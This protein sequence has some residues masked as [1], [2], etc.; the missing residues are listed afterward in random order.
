MNTRNAVGLAVSCLVAA[1]AFA[2]FDDVMPGVE[3]DSLATWLLLAFGA[4]WF[5]AG[6][7]T[8]RRRASGRAK[9]GAGGFLALLVVFGGATGPAPASAA[10][11]DLR[12]VEAAERQD[13]ESARALLEA[14]ADINAAQPDG[15]TA[16]HWAV[17]WNDLPTAA[18][19]IEAGAAIDAVN[20]L[21][22]PP[23]WIALDNGGAA[24]ALQLIEAGADVRARLPSGETMLMTAARNGLRTLVSRL[25]AGGADVRLAEHEA[26]QTALM[27]AAAGGHTDLVRLLAESGA[28]V[29]A[30]STG[31]FTALMFAVRAGDVESA[32]ILLDAGAD[33]EARAI[34]RS[35][36][37][38]IASR[39]T[40]ALAG[41][42]WRVIPFASG[43]EETAR[44]L[45]ERGADVTAFDRLGR[46]AIHAAV[47][48]N[49]PELVRAL[50]AAGADVNA[51]YADRVPA[52]RGDY[53]SRAPFK[54]ATPFWVA[55]RDANLEMMRL[56]LDA[57]AD[58]L[59]PNTANTTPLMIASGLGENDARRPPDHRVVEA[60]QMLLDLGADV[61]AVNRSGQTALHGAASMWEDGVIQLL[62]DNGADVNAEDGSGRT[63]LHLVEYGNANAPSESTAELLRA[64]GAAEPVVEQ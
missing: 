11:D 54:G 53:V 36:P 57:G 63:P 19:L 48:T 44:L 58:P 51:R 17:H 23:L 20:D 39:S 31:R 9:T 34:D 52:L 6:C 35:T 55:A 16:L 59:L 3:S 30:R 10:N 15:A 1:L 28:D 22:V 43:H 2:A 40:D 26:G 38:L 64:L 24:M 32:R 12:V 60:V 14:G 49:R 4:V 7:R 21:G 33:I 56:L 37:L 5:L 62:V 47:E 61:S 27:W 25:I 45:I 18:A 41:I 46:T 50:V 42:D 8:C 13:W 29:R